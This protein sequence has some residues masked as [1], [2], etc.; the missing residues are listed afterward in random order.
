MG[1]NFDNSIVNE[2]TLRPLCEQVDK[3]FP[4][5]TDRHYRFFAAT[6]DV[7]LAY[8]I[9]RYY[10][11][12]QVPTSGSDE[13]SRYVLGR[14]L[15]PGSMNYLHLVYIRD[16]TCVDPTGCVV[17]Y[18]HELQHIVQ[19]GFPK[20]VKANSTLREALTTFEPMP[21]EIDLPAEADANIVSKR[22]AEV[23]CGV[24]AVREFGEERVRFMLKAGDREQVVRWNFF[25][26]TPSSTAYDF[27]K[28]TLKLVEKYRGRVGFEMDINKPDW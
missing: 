28:E 3:H 11:G 2:S 4:L 9:G 25:L 20:L 5:P 6:Q 14:Y 10:R 22:V 8:K 19:Y 16:I 18:A 24:D 15:P 7:H 23:I 21:T 27:E 26:D 1:W 12:F 17:T 13:V